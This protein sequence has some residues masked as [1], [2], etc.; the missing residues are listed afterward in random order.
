MHIRDYHLNHLFDLFLMGFMQL[1]L[2]L[3][4]LLF[5]I[6]FHSFNLFLFILQSFSSF[7]VKEQYR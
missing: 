2:Q 3:K 5:R 1:F 7:L 4:Y 6:S